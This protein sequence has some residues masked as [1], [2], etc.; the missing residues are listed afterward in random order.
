VYGEHIAESLE[1]WQATLRVKLPNVVSQ[2]D[3]GQR[4]GRKSRRP[5]AASETIS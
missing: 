2:F 1:Q 4:T 5:V 3:L